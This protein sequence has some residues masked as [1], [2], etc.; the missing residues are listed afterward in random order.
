MAV[1][2]DG[3]IEAVRYSPQGAISVVRAYERRGAAFSDHILLDR[4][5]LVQRLK[6]GQKF[7]TGQR[8][9]FQGG[10]FYPG[11]AVRLVQHGGQ[12]LL[13]A[14]SSSGEHDALEGVPIF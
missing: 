11:V 13:I 7:T 10:V 9:P 14:G 6:K 12:D 1:K 3:V 4:A 8:V 5:T 2:F